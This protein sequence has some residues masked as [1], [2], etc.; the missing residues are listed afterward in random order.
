[1]DTYKR[2]WVERFCLDNY[3][4]YR[5]KKKYKKIPKDSSKLIRD[6]LSFMEKEN[7]HEFLIEKVEGFVPTKYS[8]YDQYDMNSLSMN[9]DKLVR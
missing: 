7:A 2:M 4:N 1:M 6:E 8:M 5:M 3:I 9:Y